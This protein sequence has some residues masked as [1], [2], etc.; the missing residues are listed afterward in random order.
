MG[1]KERKP[2]WPEMMERDLEEKLAKTKTKL[3][4]TKRDVGSL[5]RL[6]DKVENVQEL[7]R[8]YH[9]RI[10]HRLKRPKDGGFQLQT[11]KSQDVK[12]K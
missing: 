10:D 2:D 8:E 5:R 11:V 12:K 9:L 3:P 7:L 4:L 1:E 6:R